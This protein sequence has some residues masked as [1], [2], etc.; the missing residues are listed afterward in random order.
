MTQSASA[1][2]KSEK[3]VRY[4]IIELK[5]GYPN[6]YN[7]IGRPYIRRVLTNLYSPPSQKGC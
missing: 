2:K 4:L 7:S 5:T 3:K 6:L 1:R